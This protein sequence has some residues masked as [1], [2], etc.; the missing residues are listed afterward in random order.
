MTVTSVSSGSVIVGMTLSG[1]G[2]TA[3]TTII[4]YDGV[5][6]GFDTYTVSAS[7]SVGSATITGTSS[8]RLL[9]IYSAWDS[10]AYVTLTDGATITPNFALGYNFQVTINGT[11]NLAAPLNPKLGQSGLMLVTC[12][13]PATASFTGKI[14]NT[15]EEPAA[16]T[17]LT[18]SAVSSGTLAIGT[19]I[20]GGTVA[21]GTTITAFG[22]GSGTVGTYT[23]NQSQLTAPTALTGTTGRTLTYNAAYKFP[24]GI[25][26]T[27]DTGSGRLNIL[28]YSVYSVSPL[29]IVVSC[30]SGVR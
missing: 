18:V 1:T 27:L 9:P 3:G 4:S 26:P 15:A 12:G 22:T 28:T 25:A 10:T 14:D 20:T 17:T 6:G 16:G 2:V 23:V 7:Q 24:G 19:V 30:L 21:A 8:N 5:V 29:N 11:R 13:A